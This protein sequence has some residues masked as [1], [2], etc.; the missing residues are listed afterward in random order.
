[1]RQKRALIRLGKNPSSTTSLFSYDQDNTSNQSTTM[2]DPHIDNHSENFLDTKKPEMQRNPF[3]I[4]NNRAR[5]KALG[6]ASTVEA[7][8]KLPNWGVRWMMC[9]MSRENLMH[10]ATHSVELHSA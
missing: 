3:T 2:R 7:H 1:M 10:V 4:A 9:S 5:A 6:K 8:Q